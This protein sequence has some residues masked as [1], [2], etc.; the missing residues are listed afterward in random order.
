MEPVQQTVDSWHPQM[1]ISNPFLHKSMFFIVDSVD[2]KE[3][4]LLMC[5]TDGPKSRRVACN[6]HT[7]VPDFCD[8]AAG[9]RD[10]ED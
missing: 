5:H 9:R 6:V 7:L 2:Y 8:I 10:W 1:C 3:Q 4:G